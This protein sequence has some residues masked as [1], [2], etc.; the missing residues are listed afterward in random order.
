LKSPSDD[1]HEDRIF[2][3]EADADTTGLRARLD[4]YSRDAPPSSNG[5]PADE[6]VTPELA[7]VDPDLARRARELLPE[8]TTKPAASPSAWTPDPD[9]AGPDDGQPL[10]TPVLEAEERRPRRKRRLVGWMLA[11]TL[12]GAAAGAALSR[13]TSVSELVSD[14]APESIGPI[15][16]RSS[17]SPAEPPASPSSQG[18]QPQSP[19]AASPP[20]VT[21]TTGTAPSATPPTAP[22]PT[23]P[24]RRAAPSGRDFAWVPAPGAASYLV[25]FYRGRR[26]IFRAQPRRPRLVLPGQWS[27]K[28]HEYRLV[29]GRYRWSVRPRLRGSQGYGSPIVRAKLVIQ[30][31]SGDQ[32]RRRR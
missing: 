24:P 27:F 15:G 14:H 17:P 32:S 13:T 30:R 6:P 16:D 8:P 1:T 18:K 19:P 11:V 2:R 3:G 4:A 10:P 28:G 5:P 9:D 25:Q 29:P 26:E 7:L 22:T 12:L 21:A 23:A 20:T 31:D